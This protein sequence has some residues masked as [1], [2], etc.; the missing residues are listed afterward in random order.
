MLTRKTIKIVIPSYNRVEKLQKTIAS[1]IE[2]ANKSIHFVSIFV[3]N[4]LSTDD[5]EQVLKIATNN[6]SRISY[7]TRENHI[8]GMEHIM[9]LLTEIHIDADWYWTLGND[10]LI[11]PDA[12]LYLDKIISSENIDYIHAPV[13]QSMVQSKIA[14]GT[15]KEV[16]DS[17]GLLSLFGFFS[18]NIFSGDAIKAV[19]TEL[20][21]NKDKHNKE[22]IFIHIGIFYSAL[23]DLNAK[24]IR[25]M[26]IERQPNPDQEGSS[27]STYFDW[28]RSVVCIPELFRA[29]DLKLPI[30]KRVFL[31]DGFYMW[32]LY[33]AD[34]TDFYFQNTQNEKISLAKFILSYVITLKTPLDIVFIDDEINNDAACISMA[35]IFYRLEILRLSGAE[36]DQVSYSLAK[37]EVIKLWKEWR[38]KP[39]P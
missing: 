30:S 2:Y 29:L 22:Y 12:H 17:V 3:S 8:T 20:K 21:K 14:K 5:T 10:D 23:A 19:Q 33:L 6:D 36:Y 31:Y 13:L 24:V 16:V 26:L 11:L 4:N 15:V 1:V 32:R 35:I 39:T 7:R 25:Q 37:N 28:V 27:K 34:I 18:S 38:H 9:E